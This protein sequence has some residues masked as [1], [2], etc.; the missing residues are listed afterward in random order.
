MA[1]KM[2]CAGPMERAAYVLKRGAP[3]ADVRESSGAR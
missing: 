3:A 1:V 2:V